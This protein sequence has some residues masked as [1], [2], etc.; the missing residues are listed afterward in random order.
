MVLR[1][2]LGRG[3]LLRRDVGRRLRYERRIGVLAG[4]EGRPNRSR[5][6]TG[7]QKGYYYNTAQRYYLPG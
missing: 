2:A 5:N 7:K 4:K 3:Q 1:L 6:Y